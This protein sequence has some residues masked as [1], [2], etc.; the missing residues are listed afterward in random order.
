MVQM[1]NGT[2][3]KVPKRFIELCGTEKISYKQFKY[4]SNY[5]YYLIVEQTL[6]HGHDENEIYDKVFDYCKEKYDELNNNIYCENN[7]WLD[8]MKYFFDNL[9]SRHKNKTGP[10]NFS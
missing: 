2:E 1:K 3:L 9:N 7:I 8:H 4:K 10:E 6:F 5:Y